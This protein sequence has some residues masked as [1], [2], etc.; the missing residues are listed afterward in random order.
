MLNIKHMLTKC[1]Y[2]TDFL[3]RIVSCFLFS[4]LLLRQF[5]VKILIFPC[6]KF[7]FLE[8]K[9]KKYSV[10][11][12]ISPLL[13]LIST[14]TRDVHSTLVDNLLGKIKHYLLYMRR[15]ICGFKFA[16]QKIVPKVTFRGIFSAHRVA[17]LVNKCVI[18]T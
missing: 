13:K 1:F 18:S 15:E 16:C 4:Q 10:L 14:N 9:Y 12:H 7:I 11:K 5:L 17:F 8:I 6:M 3:F 2:S